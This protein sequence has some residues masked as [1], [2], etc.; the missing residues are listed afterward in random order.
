MS[1]IN[2]MQPAA[3]QAAH[4]NTLRPIHLSVPEQPADKTAIRPFR[5][6]FPEAELTELRKRI[7]ATRWPDRETVTDQSEGP[8]LATLQKLA[9]LG[10]RVRLAQGR[11]QTER[12][13]EFHYRDRRS[14]HSLHSRS[15]ET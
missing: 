6:T 10:E 9:L 8:Q 12:P 4:K 2:T 5:V 14:R 1:E 3:E 7:N 11:G 13:A 15:F